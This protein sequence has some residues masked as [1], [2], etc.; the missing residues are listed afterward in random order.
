MNGEQ[1]FESLKRIG[2]ADDSQYGHV[3]VLLDVWTGQVLST[4][5]HPEKDVRSMTVLVASCEIEAEHGSL[6]AG[7]VPT[8]HGEAGD[9]WE[10]V[11]V[12]AIEGAVLVSTTYVGALFS[13]I[14]YSADKFLTSEVAA[15][16]DED[17]KYQHLNARLN[18]A[19]TRRFVNRMIQ[20]ALDLEGEDRQR[21]VQAAE[22]SDSHLAIVAKA[23]TD[24]DGQ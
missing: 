8:V 7:G 2:G 21:A 17:T 12:Q 4:T 20:K 22:M 16:M 18:Y 9:S 24:V 6:L 1:L 5:F 3:N 23:L 11:C 14:G 13:E 15:K 10:N 19:A